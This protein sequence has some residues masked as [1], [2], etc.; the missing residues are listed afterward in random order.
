MPRHHVFAGRDSPPQGPG[1]KEGRE[2]AQ[3]CRKNETGSTQV[4]SKGKAMK[5][6]G[7][8]RK[9]QPQALTTEQLWVL[10][11]FLSLD[12]TLADLRCALAGAFEIDFRQPRR[13]AAGLARQT[14]VM[15]RFRLPEPGI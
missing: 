8:D 7:R 14:T 10:E 5:W 9:Q 12:I 15:S 3:S 11:R 2:T 1:Q 13:D 6:F 4:S